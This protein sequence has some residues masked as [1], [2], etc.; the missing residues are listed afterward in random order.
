[1]VDRLEVER[2][3]AFI[4]DELKWR[5]RQFNY[6]EPDSYKIKLYSKSIIEL[7]NLRTLLIVFSEHYFLDNPTNGNANIPERIGTLEKVLELADKTKHEGERSAA[8]HQALGIVKK[9]TV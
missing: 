3:L 9:M 1:M 8:V 5:E 4:R 2:A 6:L 7:R